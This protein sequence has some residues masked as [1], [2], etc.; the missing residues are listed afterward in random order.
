[1]EEAY[2]DLLEK[3]NR[4]ETL[5]RRYQG[6]RCRTC[7]PFANPL[8]GQG[9]VLSIL[10]M[11]SEISQKE[12]AYLLDMRQQSL[13]ELLQKL[14][15]SGLIT[16]IPSEDDKRV[17]TITLTE[18]GRKFT[19]HMG[20]METGA[21]DLFDCLNREEQ[22][23]LKEFLD[24]LADS[25]DRKMKPE[26]RGEDPMAVR[27]FGGH[28]R[29]GDHDFSF[30]WGADPREGPWEHDRPYGHRHH[31]GYWEGGTGRTVPRED[32]DGHENPSGSEEDRKPNDETDG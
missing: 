28:W 22:E 24:R 29:H 3:L 18:K 15:R 1:M 16:R 6:Y 23:K 7:G 19:E 25:L 20:E 30:Y 10:K 9:R 12:L 4:L 26:S 14:E 13:S 32:R 5:L 21:D 17:Y 27:G 2:R 8:R 11:M 31:A